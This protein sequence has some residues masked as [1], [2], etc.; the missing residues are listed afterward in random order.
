MRQAEADGLDC[1]PCEEDVVE[2]RSDTPKAWARLN[3]HIGSDD[4]G[5]VH[6]PSFMN[7]KSEQTKTLR[8]V[9]LDKKRSLSH[10]RKAS[11]SSAV[12]SDIKGVASPSLISMLS[13]SSFLSIYGDGGDKDGE[14]VVLPSLRLQS[15][16]N[17]SL[18]LSHQQDQQRGN[19]A[20]RSVSSGTFN[21]GSS[22]SA[23]APA[24]AGLLDMTS[25]LQQIERLERR[26]TN[27]RHPPKRTA[28]SC[29]GAA[30][31]PPNVHSSPSASLNPTRVREAKMDTQQRVMT[32]TPTGKNAPAHR[33]LPPTP[34]TVS[35]STLRRLRDP[36]SDMS[37]R[38]SSFEFSRR[39]S[40]DR[41]GE[42][43][44]RHASLA[45]STVQREMV[46]WQMDADKSTLLRRL[47][48]LLPPAPR[49]VSESVSTQTQSSSAQ[50]LGLGARDGGADTRSED[51][52]F[53]YWMWE[54]TRARDPSPLDRDTDSLPDL[55]EVPGTDALFGAI[56]GSGF[57][58][59]PGLG[60]DSP[61]GGLASSIS[62]S[63]D[64][65][66]GP[67]VLQEA[68]GLVAPDRRPNLRARVGSFTSS[69]GAP[70]GESLGHNS[71][72][73]HRWLTSRGGRSRSSSADAASFCSQHMQTSCAPGARRSVY[74]PIAGQPARSRGLSGLNGLFRRDSTSHA[75]CPSPRQQK[76]QSPCQ[77]SRSG[78]MSVPPPAARPWDRRLPELSDD[79][80]AGATPPPIMRQRAPR[81]VSTSGDAPVA[82]NV[83]RMQDQDF[84]CATRPRTATGLDS[85]GRDMAATPPR[86]SRWL[87]LG[88]IGGFKKGAV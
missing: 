12:P 88:L 72:R 15:P 69:G 43:A 63:E 9:V 11:G 34:D 77:Y 1:D 71:A 56:R 60:R 51:S 25:P 16:S 87:G 64:G 3:A 17:A 18:G 6:M 40:S 65:T 82:S 35:T 27:R 45:A 31:E 32:S 33:A 74:P 29:D 22:P 83:G 38:A 37:S 47:T 50:P 19:A 61:E 57:S 66:F 86:R 26:Y 54:G 80:R 23:R 59:A 49:S 7:E 4:R 53:D 52:N 85:G 62:D 75:G 28:S 13:E 24:L 5:L 14:S 21:G 76:A 46:A 36:E 48:P 39:P 42:E 44:V 58:P 10:L 79:D 70:A 67:T 41:G 73:E 81:P 30:S 8:S 2:S 78:R 55:F 84:E 68:D 20:P